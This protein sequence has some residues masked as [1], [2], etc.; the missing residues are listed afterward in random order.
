MWPTL[1]LSIINWLNI[2]GFQS[3]LKRVILKMQVAGTK[4]SNTGEI[5]NLTP[6][7]HFFSRR[8]ALH[9]T[10]IPPQNK[11]PCTTCFLSSLLEH[12]FFLQ[13]L[14]VLSKLL[15]SRRFIYVCVWSKSQAK[16]LWPKWLEKWLAIGLATLKSAL[17]TT[18]KKQNTTPCSTSYLSIFVQYVIHL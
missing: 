9:T 15:M 13:V 10:S 11:G 7:L 16:R 4:F 12:N 5:V 6:F 17:K 18:S 3:S 8:N 2:Q 14:L 1:K